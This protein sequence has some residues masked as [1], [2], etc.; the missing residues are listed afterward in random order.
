MYSFTVETVLGKQST[1]EFQGL[2]IGGYPHNEDLFGLNNNVGMNTL[3]SFIGSMQQ[4][5]FN[6]MHYFEMARAA[7][8]SN[9]Q[10]GMKIINIIL[11][12]IS[13]H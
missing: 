7:G 11:K 8:N 1:L 12:R 3:P 2:Y 6:G 13:V 5:S 4:F 9:V 10:K